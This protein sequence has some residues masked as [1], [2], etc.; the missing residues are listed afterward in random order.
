MNKLEDVPVVSTKWKAADYIGAW[1]MRLDIGRMKYKVEPGL[2]AVGSPDVKSPVLVSANY[3][4]SFDVLRRELEGLNV[5]ILVIDTKG[6]NVW[7]AAGK[8]TFGTMEIVRRLGLTELEK[9]IETRTLIVPQLGAPGVA[10]HMV[11]AFSGFNVKFGPVRARDIKAYLAAG[12]KATPEMRKVT[13]DLYERLEVSWMEMVHTLK[14]GLLITAVLIAAG[15]FGF[16]PAGMLITVLWSGI[17]AGSVFTAALLP[18]LPGRAFSIKGAIAGAITAACIVAVNG[19]IWHTAVLVSAV[20]FSASVSA[21]VALNYTG[22]ST[23]TSLSGVNREI[24]FALPVIIGV[25]ALS[26]LL[27]LISFLGRLI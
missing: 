12:M 18:W 4:L 3:K 21:Y 24:K 25:L 14:P 7:C 15:L 11:K 16:T 2:Y 9:L 19:H 22:N 20:L 8:G 6:V 17:L 27:Q 10:G 1:K 23:Y 13:F 5:W 26:A